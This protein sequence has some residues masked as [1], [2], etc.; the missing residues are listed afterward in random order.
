MKKIVLV[1]VVAGV[2][3]FG[4]R[5]VSRWRARTAYEGFAEAWTH[6]NMVEARKY[7]TEE[8]A[9]HALQDASLRGL[10]SGSAMEA[11]RGTR[12][13]YEKETVS[14]AGDLELEVHQTIFFDPPG[15]TSAIGGA[16]FTGIHHSAKLR[17]D[18]D[19]WK[20]VAFE[21]RYIDMGPL[22]KR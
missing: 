13:R 12:Y 5:S 19:G 3:F 9:R 16:M 22:R 18:S 15:I 2:A 21:P 6:G 17:N 4:W 7:G 1:A 11:F 14:D 10:Q 8:C 20:V